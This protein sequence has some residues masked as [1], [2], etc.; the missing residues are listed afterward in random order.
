MADDVPRTGTE[1]PVTG[2]FSRHNLFRCKLLTREKAASWAMALTM[3]VV[4]L[5]QLMPA[6][7]GD[8]LIVSP[9][10][11]PFEEGT[12][13]AF[14]FYN[15]G[16]ESLVIHV[17]SYAPEGSYWLIPVWS[18]PENI[19]V[20][21]VSS[22]TLD[23]YDTGV[24]AWQAIR[25]RSAQWFVGGSLVS[26]IYPA[27]SP[28]SLPLLYRLG[29]SRPPIYLPLVGTLD[30]AA[31]IDRIVGNRSGVTVHEVVESFGLT[32][33]IVTAT[34]VDSLTRFLRGVGVEVSDEVRAVLDGYIGGQSDRAPGAS[35][36]PSFI[37]SKVSG[38][39]IGGNGYPLNSSSPIADANISRIIYVPPQG[40]GIVIT[41][42]SDVPFYPLIPT[43]IYGSK[44][45]ADKSLKSI[46]SR[47][48]LFFKQEVFIICRGGRI[49]DD[50]HCRVARRQ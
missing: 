22:L 9:W 5:P 40:L 36:V 2:L 31:I 39:P 18:K 15:A 21:H 1:V 42:P 25:S 6:I 41:F 34:D 20:S 38:S 33:Y 17:S 43:S 44:I 29:I 12:Q 16:L 45:V 32:S 28:L 24:D 49:D 27:L 3:L 7:V 19:V 50:D 11:A 14:V 37:V 23:G 10:G 26:Q 4:I 47:A 30:W 13:T 35:T 8:G 48:T 46:S